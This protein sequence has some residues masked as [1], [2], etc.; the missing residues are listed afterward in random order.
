MRSTH[1]FSTSSS[2]RGQERPQFGQRFFRHLFCDEVA[3]AESPAFRLYSFLFPEVNGIAKS[4]RTIPSF[5]PQGQNRTRNSLV[6]FAIADFQT[7]AGSGWVPST[8]AV[9][10]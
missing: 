9:Q 10:R 8:V 5:G 7:D 6:P 4:R 2:G 3:A 1:T